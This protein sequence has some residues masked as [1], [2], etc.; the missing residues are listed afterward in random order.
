VVDL[1]NPLDH[2]DADALLR[3]LE[4]Q[5]PALGRAIE[6]ARRRHWPVLYVNDDHG[7]GDPERAVM[8]AITGRGGALIAPLAPRAGEPVL[9]C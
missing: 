8:A 6:G 7:G 5:A 2:E 4:E 9:L 3:R 1:L